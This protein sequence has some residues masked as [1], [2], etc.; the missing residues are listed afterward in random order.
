MP[1]AAGDGW[2][3]ALIVARGPELHREGYIGFLELEACILVEK[4]AA[5]GIAPFI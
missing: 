1:L 5:A 3:V 2:F 4:S